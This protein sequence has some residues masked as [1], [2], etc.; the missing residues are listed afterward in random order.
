MPLP[1]CLFSLYQRVP[2][3]LRRRG[4]K[5]SSLR[6][7]F[8]NRNPMHT[9]VDCRQLWSLLFPCLDQTTAPR[10]VCIFPAAS[11][12]IRQLRK[13][14]FDTS[15]ANPLPSK[16]PFLSYSSL[17]FFLLALVVG[18]LNPAARGLWEHRTLS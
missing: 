4:L 11:L 17:P 7:M 13:N 1:L 9:V 2:P 14:Q 6:V 15:L 18:T 5:S 3:V 8:I 10:H 16:F 12:I